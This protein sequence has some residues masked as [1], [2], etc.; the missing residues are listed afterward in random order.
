MSPTNQVSFA[1]LVI[2]QPGHA[3]R[4]LVVDTDVVTV[5]R[6][7]DNLIALESDSNVSRYHAEIEASRDTFTIFDLDSR[8]GTTVNDEPVKERRLH[9][10]DL[11]C[12]GGSTIIEFHLSDVPWDAVES[13]VAPEGEMRLAGSEA[14]APQVS[15]VDINAPAAPSVSPSSYV[16]APQMPPVAPASTGLSARYIVGGILG[17]LL[18]TGIVGGILWYSSSRG[19][20]ATVRF[21]NPQ[22]GA[23]LKS[24]IPIRVEAENTDCVDRVIYELDGVKVASSE[25][26]P[27]EATLDPADISGLTPGN[28]VLTVTVEDAKGNRTV[29]P[30]EV[31]LGF[32][33]AKALDPK[34]TEDK[35][36]S[37]DSGDRQ[38]ALQGQRLSAV[39]IKEMTDRLLKELSPKRE[40][41]LDRELLHQIDARTAEY[42]SAGFY[43]RARPFRDVIN[44]SFVNQQGLEKPVGFILAMSRSNFSVSLSSPN[45]TSQGLG[46]W[47]VPQTLAQSAGYT[48]Q[49][50]T[51]T[52]ADKDQKCSAIVAAA[53]LK[54]L[55]VD[56]FGGDILYAV[57][58]FG[59]D[60]K[61]AAQW[62]DQLPPDRRDVWNV[63][64]SS[65]QRDRAAR[66][67]AAGI[68][69]ENP[70][71][72]GLETET[73]LSNLYPK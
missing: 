73:P 24:A 45:D 56:L 21:T 64:K 1:K 22:S 51:L 30:D 33:T 20:R 50:G 46:L 4:E 31:V 29:Q 48:G 54:A 15:A 63:I 40:Y 6:A 3:S 9:D 8:N 18:L 68:V 12:L 65:E 60:P 19:C 17:G 49:C 34:E 13:Q 27:Y 37:N 59:M 53:Y 2:I 25:I 28:H 44:D 35:S 5:G 43:S 69:A 23:V 10:E 57:A 39:E 67:L 38:N 72:F 32:E 58:C 16:A 70:Q 14:A 42:A 66:F 41:T 36:S 47:R 52:L 55:E 7:F 11:I 26:A 62:R 71:R 61:A